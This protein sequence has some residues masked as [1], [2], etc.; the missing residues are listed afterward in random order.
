MLHQVLPVNSY[1]YRFRIVKNSKCTFCKLHEETLSHLFYDCSYSNPLWL[2]IQTLLS[3]ASSGVVKITAKDVV[4]NTFVKSKVTPL[5]TLFIVLLSEGRVVIWQARNLRKFEEK[6]VNATFILNK[7]KN[8]IRLR[9]KA[10]FKRFP[11]HKFE[12][13]WCYSNS[14]CTVVNNNLS[15][16]I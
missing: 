10:D 9:I 15:V 5:N 4:F 2:Y 11:R 14:F 3:D 7:F 16:Q 1:L 13:L 8:V 6:D 12:K